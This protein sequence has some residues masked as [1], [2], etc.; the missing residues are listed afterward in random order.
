M[1]QCVTPELQGS[2]A[3]QPP[4]RGLKSAITQALKHHKHRTAITSPFPCAA[5]PTVPP[6][7]GVSNQ[8]AQ[9]HEQ[10]RTRQNI[11]KEREV[12]DL[13]GLEPATLKTGNPVHKT[14]LI[15]PS[16]P[17]DPDRWNKIQPL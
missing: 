3:N 17:K 2:T 8:G 4:R 6:Y 11:D 7:L 5:I 14:L 10:G 1:S 9:G 16:P 12:S 13:S 15:V